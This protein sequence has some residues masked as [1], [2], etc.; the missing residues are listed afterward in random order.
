MN[1]YIAAF[2]SRGYKRC[3]DGSL[4][5]GVEKIAIYSL[6]GV[7]EHAAR[8]LESG[9]WTSKLGD[10]DDISHTLEALE[11]VHYG[12]VAVFMARPKAVP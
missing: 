10:L 4:E 12:D 1:A 11:K 7:P 6:H 9:I 3:K 2:A 5:E 8:Q